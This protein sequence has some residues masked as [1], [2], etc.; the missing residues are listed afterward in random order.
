MT[1]PKPSARDLDLSAAHWLPGTG[2]TSE[3]EKIE[4]A[5]VDEYVL[6]RNSTEPDGHILVF[7]H[8]EWDAFTAGAKNGEFDVSPPS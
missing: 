6:M 5:Y 4:I 1:E 7:T 8:A 2:D 3:V